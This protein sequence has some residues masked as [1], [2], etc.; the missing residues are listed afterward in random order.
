MVGRGGNLLDHKC[1]QFHVKVLKIIFG[2]VLL[3][4]RKPAGWSQQHRPTLKES[5]RLIVESIISL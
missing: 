3:V 1:Y 4:M 2:F 5:Q